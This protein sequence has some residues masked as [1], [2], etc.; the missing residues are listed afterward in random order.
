MEEQIEMERDSQ[1]K[2]HISDKS[3]SGMNQWNSQQQDR[4]VGRPQNQ[5]QSAYLMSSNQNYSQSTRSGSFECKV[6]T[7]E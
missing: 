2:R 7:Q 1:Q 6:R 3:V 5:N 4:N